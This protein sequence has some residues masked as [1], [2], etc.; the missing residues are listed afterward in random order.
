MKRPDPRKR[1]RE[2]SAFASGGVWPGL[3]YRALQ[4]LKC[5]VWIMHLKNPLR[6]VTCFNKRKISSSG[7]FDLKISREKQFILA[8]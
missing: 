8:I 5:K 7:S 3:N 4:L 6:V 2:L 1:K